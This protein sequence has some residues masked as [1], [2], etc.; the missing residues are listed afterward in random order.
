MAIYIIISVFGII[1]IIAAIAASSEAKSDELKKL[2]E[3]YDSDLSGPN[4]REALNSGRAYYGH[5]RK[6]K[7][8]TI[9][10]EQAIANDIST[11]K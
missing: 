2:K 7:G 8:L 1:G 6:G 10:D 9:Y 4:K 5:L 11:M 3:K